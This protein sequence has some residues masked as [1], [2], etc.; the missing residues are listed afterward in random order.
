MAH[1]L[2]DSCVWGGCVD[3]LKAL[4]HQVDWCGFW[5]VDPGDEEILEHAFLKKLILVTMDKDFGELVI[6]KGK[7]HNGLIRLQGFATWQLAETI[8]YLLSSYEKELMKGALIV[9]NPNRIRL[10]PA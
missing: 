6:L 5:E 2:L 7:D 8:H 9:A 1:V 4:G 3:G 10:R